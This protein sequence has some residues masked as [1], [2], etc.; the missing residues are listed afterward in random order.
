MEGVQRVYDT[1]F[2]YVKKKYVP[3][4]LLSLLSI[5][6]YTICVFILTE[7]LMRGQI[8][9]WL[10]IGSVIMVISMIYSG[11]LRLSF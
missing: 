6:L 4:T 11:S 9:R 3:N 8:T 2:K 10:Y 5:L 1:G 7:Y